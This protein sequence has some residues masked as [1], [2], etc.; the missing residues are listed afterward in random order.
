[1]SNTVA[2]GRNHLISDWS[3]QHI[4]DEVPIPTRHDLE[5]NNHLHKSISTLGFLEKPNTFFLILLYN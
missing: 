5:S 4:A 2:K 3:S 1:M